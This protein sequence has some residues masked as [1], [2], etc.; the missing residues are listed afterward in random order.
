MKLYKKYEEKNIGYS[1]IDRPK[2]DT[3]STNLN[4]Y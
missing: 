2:S 4:I 1:M 3:E